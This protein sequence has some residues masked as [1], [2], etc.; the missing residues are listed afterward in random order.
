MCFCYVQ[1]DWWILNIEVGL[2]TFSS[3]EEQWTLLFIS[4]DTATEFTRIAYTAVG[5]LKWW[6]TQQMCGTVRRKEQSRP[7]LSTP[8]ND[9]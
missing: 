3:R 2:H 6:R 7:A 5:Q 8:T 9:W 4:N 1:Q